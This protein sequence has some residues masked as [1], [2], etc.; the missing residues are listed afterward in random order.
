MLTEK[1]I[2]IEEDDAHFINEFD[3][4]G[5]KSSAELLSTA[6]SLLKEELQ[7]KSELESSALLLWNNLFQWPTRAGDCPTKRP[8]K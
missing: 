3:H 5:F 8:G 7:S 2:A 4:Y 6:L 1:K